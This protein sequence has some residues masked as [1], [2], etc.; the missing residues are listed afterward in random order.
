MVVAAA[1]SPPEA[2]GKKEVPHWLFGVAGCWMLVFLPAFLVLH[3]SATRP[4]GSNRKSLKLSGASQEFA[5]A[6]NEG[7]GDTEPDA[8]AERAACSRSGSKGS[9]GGPFC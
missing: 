9:L 4:T 3:L 8:V 5:A 7:C 1:L 6:I 2:P